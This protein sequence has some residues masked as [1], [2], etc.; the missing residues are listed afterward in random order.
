[1]KFHDA[2]NVCKQ[3]FFGRRIRVPGLGRKVRQ[4]MFRILLFTYARKVPRR[5][6]IKL[7]HFNGRILGYDGYEL[8]AE[9]RDTMRLG[10]YRRMQREAYAEHPLPITATLFPCRST[11]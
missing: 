2:R 3:P 8:S 1:M 6:P 9:D 10:T 11:L 4:F 5:G 7:G